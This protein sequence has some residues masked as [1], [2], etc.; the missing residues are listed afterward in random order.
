MA[1]YGDDDAFGPGGRQ[2]K[3]LS[4]HLT[5][6]KRLMRFTSHYEAGYHC[7]LGAFA[8]SFARKYDLLDATLGAAGR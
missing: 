7:R 4:H 8:L 2:A 1:Y 5:A 6:P 3:L